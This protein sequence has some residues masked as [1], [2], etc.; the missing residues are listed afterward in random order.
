[1]NTAHLPEILAPHLY[2]SDGALKESKILAAIRASDYTDTVLNNKLLA[3]ISEVGR[4]GEA[5]YGLALCKSVQTGLSQS[6]VSESWLS[7]EIEVL[8]AEMH[9][10]LGDDKY[11]EN[12]L[13][14]ILQRQDVPEEMLAKTQA[15]LSLTYF[16]RGRISEAASITLSI[17]HR[18][19]RD[20]EIQLRVASDAARYLALSQEFTKASA[21]L[22]RII[23]GSS[24][25]AVGEVP[26]QFFQLRVLHA[27]TCVETGNYEAVKSLNDELDLED[28]P[29]R[30]PDA[31]NAIVYVN[32]LVD[33]ATRGIVLGEAIRTSSRRLVITD[34]AGWETQVHRAWSMVQSGRIGAAHAMFKKLVDDSKAPALPA[35]ILLGESALVGF[36]YTCQELQFVDEARE[37][38]KKVTRLHTTEDLAISTTG[39][40]HGIDLVSVSK[41]TGTKS[42]LKSIRSLRRRG[43]YS[44]GSHT[45]LVRKTIEI[46]CKILNDGGLNGDEL[47]LRQLLV[48]LEPNDV[49]MWEDTHLRNRLHLASLC[50][51]MAATETARSVVLPVLGRIDVVSGENDE[52]N[53]FAR[54]VT[55]KL[56]LDNMNADSIDIMSSLQNDIEQHL[57]AAHPLNYKALFVLAKAWQLVGNNEMCLDHLLSIESGS[58]FATSN[59]KFKLNVMS[60][61][62]D[63]L[64]ALGQYKRAAKWY[65]ICVKLPA[66]QFDP[67][68]SVEL[69]KLVKYGEAMA[70]AGDFTGSR[71]LFESIPFEQED[72]VY[73]NA[74]LFVRAKASSAASAESMGS[75]ALAATEYSMLIS[76]M[77]ENVE[78]DKPNISLAS[79]Y[80]SAGRN[81]ELINDRESAF[82]NYASALDQLHND[83]QADKALISEITW[84]R[85]CC[86]TVGSF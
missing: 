56:D 58:G 64:S 55:F 40:L 4:R 2:P 80:I 61:I 52:L 9:L 10:L 43:Q 69:E 28:S 63:T 48:E 75:H 46:E 62:G 79:L 44:L 45:P 59:R 78:L 49:D 76:L 70:R 84:R 54:Y 30:D 77:T 35:M 21:L 3:F 23:D 18:L 12:N 50:S 7:F 16:R 20:T 83:P 32:A 14:N 27:F 68:N 65:K 1:M 24:G 38:L 47:A 41:E 17:L 81:F 13:E 85:D 39:L 29:L 34:D 8:A 72:S 66:S 71:N 33:A 51:D 31:H 19:E 36:I 37:A 5:G 6:G 26:S 60:E 73:R 74:D 42:R 67:I 57:G 86:Q 22:S 82:H 11:D 53:L 15:V 25:E